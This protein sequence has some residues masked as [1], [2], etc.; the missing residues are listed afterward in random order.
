MDLELDRL[1]AAVIS[2]RKRLTQLT[3]DEKNVREMF[4]YESLRLQQDLDRKLETINMDRQRIEKGILMTENKV[5][6]RVQKMQQ[7]LHKS[8]QDN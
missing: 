1:Q 5:R 7:I 2:E 3:L 8:G 6:D 4:K